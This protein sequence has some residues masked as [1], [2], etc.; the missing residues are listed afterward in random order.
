MPHAVML[1]FTSPVSNETEDDYNRWYSEKH[2]QDLVALPGV[3]AATR[4]KINHGVETLPG[5]SGPQQQY[6]AIYEI[7]GSTDE[8]LAQFTATLRAALGDG[9]ADIAETL[10]MA[11][12]GATIAVPI[13]ERLVAAP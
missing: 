8:E 9:R 13:T 11:D 3:I 7:E 5:V 6:L 10:D 1:A 2:I 4:Y 12:L